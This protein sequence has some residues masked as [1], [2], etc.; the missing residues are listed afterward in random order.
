M[1]GDY[2]FLLALVASISIVS[3]FFV[4]PT[5]C[6][7]VESEEKLY[8]EIAIGVENTLVENIRLD[9][10]NFKIDFPL[11]KN[12]PAF[13]ENFKNLRIELIPEGQRF[14]LFFD[15]LYDS[16]I[17]YSTAISYA[18]TIIQHLLNIFDYEDMQEL[19][20]QVK[21]KESAIEI[22]ATYGYGKNSVEEVLKFI[23]YKPMTELG[24]LVNKNLLTRYVPGINTESFNSG[25]FRIFYVLKKY[26]SDFYFDFQIYCAN[27]KAL[28]KEVNDYKE[29]IDVNELLN[30]EGWLTSHSSN[31]KIIGVI[32]KSKST[33]RRTYIVNIDKIQPD[34]YKLDSSDP[35]YYVIEFDSSSFPLRNIIVE[36]TINPRKLYN[37]IPVP[38][39]I[40]LIIVV[41]FIMFFLFLKKFRRKKT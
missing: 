26:D 28:S 8:F 37:G 36:L 18:N 23:E 3:L 5:E 2:K 19:E 31:L 17:G 9:F 4:A 27:T 14:V 39:A 10:K 1:K 6:K 25:I 34:I 7:E 11:N 41:G 33:T 40:L 29:V 20:S 38:Y 13:G 24:K 30:N 35:Y 16:S 22:K 12:M 32:Q 21:L 15:I